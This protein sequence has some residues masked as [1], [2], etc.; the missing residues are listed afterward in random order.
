MRRG[1]GA[2]KSQSERRKTALL[3]LYRER[4]KTTGKMPKGTR[5]RMTTAL[6][7]ETPTA[8]E[9]AAFYD[10]KRLLLHFASSSQTAGRSVVEMTP[11]YAR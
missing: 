1:V 2:L 9:V 3:K 11:L 6:R 7:I 10:V 5:D 8:A 4:K